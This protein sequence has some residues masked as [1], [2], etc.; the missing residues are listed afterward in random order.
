VTATVIVSLGICALALHCLLAWVWWPLP[1]VVVA[2][3]MAIDQISIHRR[4]RKG[5]PPRM[6]S[7]QCRRRNGR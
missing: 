2:T 6:V 3:G 5:R 1:I 7:L 4:H